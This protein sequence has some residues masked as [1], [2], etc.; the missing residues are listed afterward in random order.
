MI[1]AKHIAIRRALSVIKLTAA[2]AVIQP[3]A[4]F[5]TDMDID[6]VIQ[7]RAAITLSKISDMNFGI[8][9]YDT[10]HSGQIQLATDNGVSLS[11]SSSGLTLPG[12][13][14]SSAAKVDV[15]GDSQSTVE[16]S[17]DSAGTLSDGDAHTLALQNVELAIDSGTSYGSGTPCAGVGVTSA[18]VDLATNPSPT[19]LLGGAV[20]A[21]PNSITVSSAFSTANAGGNP[22]KLRVVYQ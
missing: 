14:T 11:G 13:I 17:C 12:G 5:A 3:Y 2:L 16:I 1:D 8:V 18:A 15:S 7:T 19:I 4:A 20:D 6:A 21:G 10:A 22:V 9:E